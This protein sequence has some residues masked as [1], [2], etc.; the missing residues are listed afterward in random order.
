MGAKTDK[1]MGRTKQAVGALT[2]DEEIKREGERQEDKGKLKGKLDSTIDKAHHALEDLKHKIDRNRTTVRARGADAT[3]PARGRRRRSTTPP[4]GGHTVARQI[5]QPNDGVSM[6][7]GIGSL[8]YLVVGAVIASSHHYFVH[9]STLKP[10]LSAV[11]AV[12][13]WPLLLVG[14]NLHIH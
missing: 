5:P 2:G 4:C 7:S 13:L 10:L 14:I 6:R 12:A 11:L 3:G 9:V 8:V 1:T